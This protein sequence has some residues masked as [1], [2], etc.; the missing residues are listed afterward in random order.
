M[1]KLELKPMIEVNRQT[2]KRV[3]SLVGML[4]N[5]ILTEKI[6]DDIVKFINKMGKL[7]KYSLKRYVVVYLD[8]LAKKYGVPITKNYLCH[9]YDVNSKGWMKRLGDLRRA[10][11][12]ADFDTLQN[13]VGP[14]MKIIEEMSETRVIGLIQYQLANRCIEQLFIDYPLLKGGNPHL[15]IAFAAIYTTNKKSLNDVAYMFYDLDLKL[16][17]EKSERDKTWYYQTFRRVTARA[18]L[19]PLT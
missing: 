4:G 17:R 11:L 8:H 9:T 5:E 15:L 13:F 2:I 10:G 6:S 3:D 12:I 16:G 18:G 1:S 7:H 19:V 14:A